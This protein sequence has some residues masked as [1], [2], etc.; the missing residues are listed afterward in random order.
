MKQRILGL[1]LLTLSLASWGEDDYR[2]VVQ[3]QG[4]WKDV[5][6]TKTI[7]IRL[8]LSSRQMWLYFPMEL[9]HIAHQDGVMTARLLNKESQVPMGNVSFNSDIYAVSGVLKFYQGSEIDS[10]FDGLCYKPNSGH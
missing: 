6:T 4:I 3:T 5:Q 2:C 8:L 7:E 9:T 1:L 10:D